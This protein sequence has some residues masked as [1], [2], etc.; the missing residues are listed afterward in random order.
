M[1]LGNVS[2]KRQIS[3]DHQI[4]NENLGETQKVTR[5]IV[6]IWAAKQRS[7][8]G[9]GM[10]SALHFEALNAI[11]GWTWELKKTKP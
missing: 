10:L 11:P 5:E 9:K 6:D 8:Y 7:L 4:G 1:K 2:S 3:A